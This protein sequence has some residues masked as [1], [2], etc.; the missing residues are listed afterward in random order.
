MA[1]KRSKRIRHGGVAIL[2]GWGNFHLAVF[3]SCFLL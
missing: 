1:T 3:S 2:V